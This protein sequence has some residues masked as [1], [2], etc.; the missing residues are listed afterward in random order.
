M[1]STVY[2]SLAE[3]VSHH[4]DEK[5]QRKSEAKISRFPLLQAKMTGVLCCNWLS[6]LDTW[7]LDWSGLKQIK[8]LVFF[9]VVLH[10]RNPTCGGSISSVPEPE[11]QVPTPVTLGKGWGVHWAIS[12]PP[13]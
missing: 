4:S 10:S 7:S 3:I 5:I 2:G 13:R 12:S 9:V 6:A 11:S 8:P 1:D